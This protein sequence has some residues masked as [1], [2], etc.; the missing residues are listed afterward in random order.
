MQAVVP[1]NAHGRRLIHHHTY[2]VTTR[3]WL[4]FTPSGGRSRSK[5]IYGLHFG[6]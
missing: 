4:T 1:P 6:P 3:L 5:G 2:R